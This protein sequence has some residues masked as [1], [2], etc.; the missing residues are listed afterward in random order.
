MKQTLIAMVIAGVIAGPAVLP[1]VAVAAPPAALS[2]AT[3]D[4]ATTPTVCPLANGPLLAAAGVCC[5]QKG[6]I[7][8]CRNGVPKCCNGTMG[9]DCAPSSCRADTPTTDAEPRN[10]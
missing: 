10:P 8:G 9:V 4:S 5:Q 2:G 1:L 6:G 3:P 7:C